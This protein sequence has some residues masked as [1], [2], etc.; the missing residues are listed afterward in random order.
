MRKIRDTPISL[1]EGSSPAEIR[2]EALSESDSA[3][4]SAGSSDDQ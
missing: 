2:A 1:E 3:T 4:P